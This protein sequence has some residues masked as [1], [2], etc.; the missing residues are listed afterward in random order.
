MRGESKRRGHQYLTFLLASA[1]GVIEA[2]GRTASHDDV[3]I[4][5]VVPR[6]ASC[7]ACGHLRDLGVGGLFLMLPIIII[8]VSVV[9]RV[10]LLVVV[11]PMP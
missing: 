9:A 6:A 7:S 11:M 5:I 10:L 2:T 8:I 1:T 4:V 3:M